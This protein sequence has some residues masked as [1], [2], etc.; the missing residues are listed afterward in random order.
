MLEHTSGLLEHPR[1]K[2]SELKLA[3]IKPVRSLYVGRR[4]RKDRELRGGGCY[5][6]REGAVM[7]IGRG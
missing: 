6:E 4:R 3:L 7:M 2:H 5:D 1:C